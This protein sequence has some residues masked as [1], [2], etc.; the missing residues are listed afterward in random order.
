MSPRLVP[1]FQSYLHLPS[2]N[3]AGMYRTQPCCI[4]SLCS[5]ILGVLWTYASSFLGLTKSYRDQIHLLA[6]L[7]WANQPTQPVFL[8]PFSPDSYTQG[9]YPLSAAKHVWTTPIAQSPLEL[10]KLSEHKLTEPPCLPSSI[11]C[12]LN[13][14]R[15]L[16]P[17]L[18]LPICSPR[19]S[20]SHGDL[21]CYVMPPASG[22]SEY[23]NSL[24]CDS[25][26][27]GSVFHCTHSMQ[28]PGIFWK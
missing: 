27:H 5:G 24:L 15:I 21:V 2:A 23:S 12:C 8:T 26:F 17:Q 16:Y 14:D 22:N 7:W 11:P 1:N 13:R 3:I 18:P 19:F 4:D 25:Y 9:H 28:V 10:F 6:Y 20:V